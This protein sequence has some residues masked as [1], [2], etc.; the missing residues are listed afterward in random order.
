MGRT[1]ADD[2]VSDV[3]NILL[4]TDHF[5][6]MISHTPP[7]GSA[8]DVSA[9]VT[10]QPTNEPAVNQQ[11]TR[12]VSM[13]VLMVSK[14]IGD[15]V[16]VGKGTDVS[17]F[18]FHDRTWRAIAKWGDKGSVMIKVESNVTTSTR[19]GWESGTP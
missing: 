6:E 8:V 19:K 14:A 16:T 5:A 7:G 15:T 4:N 12:S 18:V 2:L 13:A 10:E 3:D 1:L 11:G 9:I 17:R